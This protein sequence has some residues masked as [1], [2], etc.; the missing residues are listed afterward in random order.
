MN[1]SRVLKTIEQLNQVYLGQYAGAAPQLACSVDDVANLIFDNFVSG[2]IPDPILVNLIY[3]E[4]KDLEKQGKIIEVSD[5]TFYSF[6]I[7][8]VPT[9]YF[10][11]N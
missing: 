10:I 5:L 8:D 9:Q 4:M 7:T 6:Y 2:E 3:N 1:P 11:L